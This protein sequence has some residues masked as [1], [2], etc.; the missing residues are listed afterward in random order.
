MN[1]DGL[2]RSAAWWSLGPLRAARTMNCK[3]RLHE[4]LAVCAFSVSASAASADDWSSAIRAE[5]SAVAVSAT[6]TSAGHGWLS[7]RAADASAPR[8]FDLGAERQP[9]GK[10]V[11]DFAFRT[12]DTGEPTGAVL[13]PRF[14][15]P[16]VFASAPP[17]VG[18]PR[19]NEVLLRARYDF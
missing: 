10:W 19:G 4:L 17:P 2:K 14:G 12:A 18:E 1:A 7:S 3:R 5:R 16:A 11:L 8:P 6:R 13:L 9:S 15:E